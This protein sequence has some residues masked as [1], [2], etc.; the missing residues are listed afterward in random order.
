MI[1]K[2]VNCDDEIFW[3]QR[4]YCLNHD[5]SAIEQNEKGTAKYMNVT[6]M[7]LAA[8]RLFCDNLGGPLCDHPQ[9]ENPVK[10]L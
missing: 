4:P 8:E 9:S 1:K 10:T 3:K 7:W 2:A 5:H 6:A